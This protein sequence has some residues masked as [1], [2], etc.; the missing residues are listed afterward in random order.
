M[1]DTQRYRK[2]TSGC[3][4]KCK[5][6]NKYE[7]M[8]KMEINEFAK[9]VHENAVAHGWLDD[10]RSGAEIIALCHSELSESL[11]EMRK[12]MPKEYVNIVGNV[13]TDTALFGTRKTEGVAA[14]LCDCIIRILDYLEELGVDVESV[15]MRKHLYNKSRPYKH[16]KMF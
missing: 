1:S 16:G 12:G 4:K 2:A 7:R 8:K 11:E 5:N 6:H 9:M 14:E 13:V 10:P 3:C 15:L